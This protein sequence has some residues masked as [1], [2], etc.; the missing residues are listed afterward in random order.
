MRVLVFGGR[1]FIPT[2]NAWKWLDTMIEDLPSIKDTFLS[3]R[4][5]GADS[6]GE[7]MS[8][9]WDANLETFPAD[10]KMHGKSAG[11]IRNQEM[12]DSGIDIA[13]QFPGGRGTEDMRRR[14]DRAGVK[15]VEYRGT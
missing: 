6:M 10:W 14:L 11:H 15:V 13:F 5:V 4:A 9:F 7:S 1:D 12:L 2:H 8:A 3:G